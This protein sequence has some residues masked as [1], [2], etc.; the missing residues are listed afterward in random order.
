M[1]IR[2][3]TI[4]LP[5]VPAIA[6]SAQVA[7]YQATLYCDGNAQ[8]EQYRSHNAIE[9]VRS[10]ENV[11]YACNKVFLIV[12]E[13]R[14]NKT[15][16]STFDPEYHRSG[17]NSVMTATTG[18]ELVI[19]GGEICSHIDKSDGLTVIG[20]GTTAKV[21]EGV[22]RLHRTNSA[23]VCA[24]DSGYVTLDGT[25]F[26]VNGSF[27]TPFLTD[28][29]KIAASMTTGSTTGISSPLFRTAGTQSATGCEMTAE[30]SNIAYIDAGGNLILDG[31]KLTGNGYCGFQMF[32]SDSERGCSRLELSKNK[33]SVSEGPLIMACNTKAEILFRSGNTVSMRSKDLLIAK[34][35]EWGEKGRNGAD[36]TI[37]SEKQN[38]RGNITVDSISSV[39]M[40]LRGASYAGAINADANPCA[41]IRLVLDRNSS[42]Q[43]TGDSYITSIQFDEPAD[44]ALLKQ[45]KGKFT[46]YY[47]S[48]DPANAALGGMEHAIS[49]GGRL[50]PRQ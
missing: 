48:N 10:N 26:T 34:A 47:D 25:V 13:Y 39:V 9:S 1:R 29:G 7:D 42:W 28:G 12:T 46:V 27:N 3:L 19:E 16:G 21:N 38:M 37:T 43:L 20:S 5:L 45:L 15:A 35:D 4:L 2:L 17:I 23:G 8:K 24:I 32:S 44:K 11:I 49:G 40:N 18:S 14:L 30:K 36:V 6:A 22:I 50:V 33:L 31:N 41:V